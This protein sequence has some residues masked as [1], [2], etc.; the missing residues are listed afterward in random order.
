MLHAFDIKG[1]ILAARRHHLVV[2]KR[3]A[4]HGGEVRADHVGAADRGKYSDHHDP[5][6]DLA[7]LPVGISETGP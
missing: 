4:V 6:I 1:E 7:G 2:Q 3:V 5:G